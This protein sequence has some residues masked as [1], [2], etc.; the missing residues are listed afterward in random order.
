MTAPR[1]YDRRPQAPDEAM[2][3]DGTDECVAALREWGAEVQRDGAGTW[4]LV[5]GD[6]IRARWGLERGQWVLRSRDGMYYRMTDW[7][8]RD[9]YYVEDDPPEEA[10][11]MTTW[12]RADGLPIAG[13]YD[14]VTSPD[15]LYAIDEPVEVVREEWVLAESETL[16]LPLCAEVGCEGWG[17][18][19]GLCAAHAEE[20]R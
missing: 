12:R 1:P 17:Q 3:F 5:S 14:W 4:V 10:P 9:S 19:W 15:L 6:R 13:E 16:R 8:F 11:R 7:G 20:A 18:Y 2:Q